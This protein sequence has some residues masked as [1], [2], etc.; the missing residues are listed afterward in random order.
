MAPPVRGDEGDEAADEAVLEP[1]GLQ[2]VPGDQ[3]AH[4][5]RDDGHLGPFAV[6]QRDGVEQVGELV[7]GALVGLRQS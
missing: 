7:G 6:E 2:V 4:A 1:P 3:P 5:V